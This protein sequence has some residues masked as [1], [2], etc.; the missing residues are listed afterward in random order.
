[1]RKLGIRKYQELC[2]RY[3]WFTCGSI[4][5]YEAVT[6]YAMGLT[7]EDARNTSN[8]FEAVVYMT[9]ICSDTD[10]FTVGEI[11]ALLYDVVVNL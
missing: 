2:I 3:E 9:W 10:V 6:C 4:Q 7:P 1:M 11:R 5:Q 8:R